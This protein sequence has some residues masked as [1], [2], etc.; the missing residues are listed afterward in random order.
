MPDIR[1]PRRG[2]M[3][4]WPHARASRMYACIRNWPKAE[5]KK[6]LGFIG[7]KAGMTHAIEELV[8]PLSPA[9]KTYQRFVPATIIE[10]P[11]ILPLAIRFYKRTP[12]GMKVAADIVASKTEKELSR[13]IK[14]TKKKAEEPKKFDD[15][16][17]LVYTQPKK[18]GLPNKKPEIIELGIGGRNAQEK[19][20]FAKSLMDKDI[21]VSDIFKTGQLVDTKSITKGKGYQGPVKIHGVKIRQHKAE[22]TKRGPASLGGWKAQG[23]IMYRV[24][25][26]R[27]LGLH[28]RTEYNK[29]VLK[30]G[31]KP[32]EINA[33]G[34]FPRF[35]FVKNSYML[36]KGSVAGP[37]KRP[38]I[39]TEA[40]RPHK[41]AKEAN[42]K[43]V[44]L[45]SKQRR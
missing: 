9:K 13:K 2:S 4:Y 34:G 15:I 1:R 37:A 5:Q 26:A 14:P 38:I 12:Y 45:E 3:Q 40:M 41:K 32:E 39:L 10:C 44:S 35:G 24:P 42:I 7:Y 31:D 19:L 27:K 30:M 18:T 29:L 22:K 36:I 8:D 21:K 17:L 20:E 16:R 23:K 28:Q 11:P 25:K 6:L 33:K 43:Y